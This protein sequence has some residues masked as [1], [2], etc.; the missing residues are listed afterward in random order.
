M[1]IKGLSLKS[2]FMLLA[3][4]I[5]LVVLIQGAVQ[6]NGNLKLLELSKD[7][8]EKQVKL[9][10]DAHALK[11]AVVQV[12]QFLTD[13]SATR[14]RDGLDDGF[15]MAERKARKFSTLVDDLARL[16]PD[17]AATYHALTPLFNAYYTAGKVMATAYVEQGSDG[18]NARMSMFDETAQ[19]LAGK[20]EEIIVNIEQR[21]DDLVLQQ[22]ANVMENTWSLA[23]GGGLV[24]LGLTIFAVFFGRILGQL[25]D[26]AR[27]MERIAEGD[28]SV[29]VEHKAALAEL[30][31]PM[32]SMRQQLLDIISGVSEHSSELAHS[33]DNMAA[34][35]AQSSASLT[36]QQ[37]ETMQVATAMHEMTATIQEVASNIAGAAE[38]AEQANSETSTGRRVV[39]QTIEQIRTL[40]GQIGSAAETVQRLEQD[41]Q[42][43]TAILDVILGIAEQTNLLALN[44][45]IEAARAGEQGRGF[46]V[47]ADE[48]R[49]LASRTQQSTKEINQMIEQLQVGSQQAVDMMNASCEQAQTAVDQASECGRALDTIASAVGRINDMSTQIAS[50]AEEQSAVSEEINR[51]VT[52]INDMARETSEA[53]RQ[54]AETSEGQARIAVELSRLVGRFKLAG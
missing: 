24:L 4:A 19:A 30:T 51:N 13:I 37:S 18:G 40:S 17:N 5:A 45:A 46:A 33:A 26:I 54:T 48:V 38:A 50:A 12:Q 41:S 16:D 23:T 42:A 22:E 15:E 25:P 27:N 1:S 28:L 36:Q 31:G 35:A 32:E 6:L 20:V 8:A 29:P 52:H 3:S 2:R 7:V 53:A 34:A 49:N 21:T 44:A 11:L 9:L 47:V 43:I 14:G 10:N 39:N